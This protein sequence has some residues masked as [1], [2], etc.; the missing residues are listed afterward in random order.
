MADIDKAIILY[1]YSLY[2]FQQSLLQRKQLQILS[3]SP[4]IL[5]WVFK[6]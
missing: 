2:D 1:I 3:K 5:K 4:A 6:S